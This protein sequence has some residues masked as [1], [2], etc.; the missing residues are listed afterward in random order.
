MDYN[1][2]YCIL[3]IAL[4]H[5]RQLT[6]EQAAKLFYNAGRKM[7]VLDWGNLD[8]KIIKKYQE[9]R[10]LTWIA[11]KLGLRPTTLRSYILR[12]RFYDRFGLEK[13]KRAQTISSQQR[14][15]ILELLG[16][17]CTQISIAKQLNLAP[18]TVSDFKIKAQKE[19]LYAEHIGRPE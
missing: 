11:E 17:G 16:Q 7:A 8:E 14:E 13:P 10:N 5:P 12:T 1:D 18:Q 9:N 2:N 4:L 15:K 19:G 6:P 3:A